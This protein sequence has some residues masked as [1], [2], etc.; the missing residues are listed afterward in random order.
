MSSTVHFSG[1]EEPCAVNED[2][3]TVTAALT[4]NESAQFTRLGGSRVTIYRSSVAY[5]EEIGE[6]EPVVTP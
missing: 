3:E 5:I 6:T 4:G 1:G 2:Y